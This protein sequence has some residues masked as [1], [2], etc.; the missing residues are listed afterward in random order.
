MAWLFGAGRYI[1]C[2]R[3][4]DPCFTS[5]PRWP[6]LPALAVLV[7]APGARAAERRAGDA[8][9]LRSALQAARPGDVVV[10][11][12]G[13]W[14]DVA[15]DFRAEATAKAPVRLRA[16]TPGSVV[17]TGNSRLTFLAPHLIAEGLFFRDGALTGAGAEAPSSA[18]PR[19]TAA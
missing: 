4:R 6:W 11:K 16:Q 3:C 12:N 7:W 10:M 15:I 5:G 8:D 9:E 18:S 13:V 19:I 2:A 14:K 17:L 1:V